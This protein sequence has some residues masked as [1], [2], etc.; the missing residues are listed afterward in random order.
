MRGQKKIENILYAALWALLFTVPILLMYFE[1]GHP[2]MPHYKSHPDWQGVFN[3]WGLMALFCLTFYIHNFFIA[4]LLVYRKR[5]IAYALC[6]LL[7]IVGFTLTQTLTP[8]HEPPRP[9]RLHQRPPKRPPHHPAEPAPPDRALGGRDFVAFL[10]SVMLLA[11]NV[12]AKYYFK[13]RDDRKRLADLERENLSRQLQYLKYQINPHFFMNTL[14]NIH[15]LVDIDPEKAKYAIEVLSK[16]MRY[17]LYEGNHTMAP[18]HKEMDFITHYIELMRLRYT[19]RVRIVTDLPQTLPN[20]E[21]PSLLFVTFVENAFKHGVSYA[22]ESFIEVHIQADDAHITF[23]CCNSRIPSD[24]DSH[25]GV[26]L[27]N[28]L[29]RLQLIYSNR[30]TLSIV[31][32]DQTYRVTLSLP[33]EPTT[34]TTFNS[35]SSQTLTP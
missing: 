10:I 7:L 23:T 25:G 27:T 3:A 35:S 32:S 6:C 29:R 26:G 30:Y 19:D 33:Y 15:A 8:S 18:L 17:V 2:G 24:K 11:L 16:L 12:G 9:A 21:V 28:A 34:P 13:T 22:R 14:N 4:P 20:A 31:P 5:P 1:M